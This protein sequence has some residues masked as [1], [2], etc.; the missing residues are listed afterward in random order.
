MYVV[1][2][3]LEQYVKGLFVKQFGEE[4]CSS[5]CQTFDEIVEYIRTSTPMNCSASAYSK[6]C[7]G[8][9]SRIARVVVKRLAEDSDLLTRYLNHEVTIASIVQRDSTLKRANEQVF[10]DII[11]QHKRAKQD[12]QIAVTSSSDLHAYASAASA[13]GCKEWVKAGLDWMED[14]ILSYYTPNGQRRAFIKSAKSDVTDNCMPQTLETFQPQLFSS[15]QKIRLLDVGSCY[16]PFA[17]C[18]SSHLLDVTAMDLCP[19]PDAESVLAADFLTVPLGDHLVSDEKQ[20][21]QLPFHFYD[22][23][24]L[25][26]VL[27]YLPSCEKRIEMLAKAHETLKPPSSTHTGGVLLIAE[28]ASIFHRGHVKCHYRDAWIKTISAMGFQLLVYRENVI[29]ERRMHWLAFRRT[30]AQNCDKDRIIDTGKNSLLT[31]QEGAN[32]GIVDDDATGDCA[33]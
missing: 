14:T 16:N 20:L 10:A 15:A 2:A 22:A 18:A 12:W 30:S 3:A 1:P 5:F 28:K 19:N 6:Q 29:G 8:E 11:S 7:N 32:E 27:S 26:L 23:V 17:S 24:T 33:S 25:S 13:M 9:L 31:K 21:L 4:N